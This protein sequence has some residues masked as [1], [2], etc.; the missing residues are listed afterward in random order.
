MPRQDRRRQIMQAAERLFTSRRFHEITT[1]DVARVAGVGKGTMYRYFRDK[2]DLFF[3]TAMA[4]FDELCE[5]LRRVADDAPFLEQLPAACRQVG[6]FFEARRQLFRMMQAEDFRLA[7][8]KGAVYER[9]M[10]HRRT[11]VA[12]MAGVLRRG[13]AEGVV[14]RDVPPDVL[15][16]FLL[17]MLRTRARDLEDAPEPS[18]RLER[19]LDL[20]LRGAAAAAAAPHARARSRRRAG[21]VTDAPALCTPHARARSRR[22]AGAVTDAPALCTPRARARRRRP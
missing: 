6:R 11:L 1:D 14:R 7:I 19:V 17:G 2:E 21:A 18:R 16:N 22:R 12:A 3:Q 10:E 4:G 8:S 5:L 9:W 20:F 15:A 13:V